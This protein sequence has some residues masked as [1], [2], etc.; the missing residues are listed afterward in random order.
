M[1]IPDKVA[2]FNVYD[3]KSKLIGISGEITLPTLEAITSTVSGA[4][5]LGEIE[6]PNVGHFGSMSI[7]IPWRTL[8]DTTFNFASHAGRSLVL[9][10]AIQQVD[11]NNGA[12]S[13][14]GVK[15]TMKYMSKGLD[16]GKL[17]QN[18]GME[19]KNTLEV[20]YIKVEIG[21]K[22]TLELDKLN[23]VYKLNGKDQLA[24]I[25]KLI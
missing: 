18:S 16:L 1:I 3:D 11:S 5:V 21:S 13:Y 7:E 4:G 15:I 14:L 10:G 25:N 8:L 12:L 23:A 17:S 19:S 20:F 9:R 22:T 2:N 6:T 24:A